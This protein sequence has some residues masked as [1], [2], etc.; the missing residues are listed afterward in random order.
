MCSARSSRPSTS[1]TSSRV[2]M[3]LFPVRFF[4]GLRRAGALHLRA[5]VRLL[6][7]AF[8]PDALLPVR[9]AGFAALL[10][11]RVLSAER[12][13]FRAPHCSRKLSASR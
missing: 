9:A 4:L 1:T 11:P 6:F 2:R 5:A 10:C 7:D 12:A 3:V 8:P 13:A